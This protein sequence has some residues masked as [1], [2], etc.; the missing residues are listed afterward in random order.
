MIEKNRKSF[1]FGTAILG[2]GL[3]LFEIYLY[4]RTFIPFSVPL[5]ITLVFTIVTFLIIKTDYKR[6][7]KNSA[8]FYS[9]VQSLISFGFIGCFGFMAL[10]YYLE[11]SDFEIISFPIVSKH[12]LGTKNPQPAIEINYNGV[13]KQFVFYT[14][15]RKDVNASD[16][17]LLTVQK[18]L[19]GYDI[20]KTIELTK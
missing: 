3:L 11:K 2:I 5:T 7:Y 15:Q 18:G 20:F 4:R 9:F 13:S 16:S 14:T 19:F 17:V 10:N 6:V 12:T 8:L 1:Y